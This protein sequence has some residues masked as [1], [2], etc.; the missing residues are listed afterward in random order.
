MPPKKSL[1][2]P[3]EEIEREYIIPLRFSWRKVPRYKR[4]NKAIKT[5]KEFLTKHMKIYDRDLK[6][7]KID[8][9]LNEFVWFRGIKKPPAKVKI[10]AVKSKDMDGNDIV[11]VRLSEL[12]EKLRFKKNREEK[13]ENL[14]KEKLADKL[15]I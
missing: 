13:L 11:R 14:A 10:K 15:I 12:P 7:I 1:S 6:K 5:I 9:Y 2:S 4:A 3:S 8:N